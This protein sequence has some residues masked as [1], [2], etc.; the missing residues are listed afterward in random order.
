MDIPFILVQSAEQP[1]RVLWKSPSERS[2]A[3]PQHPGRAETRSKGR[4]KL[5][6]QIGLRTFGVRRQR[7]RDTTRG[8]YWNVLGNNIACLVV[9]AGT[10]WQSPDRDSNPDPSTSHY[11][12]LSTHIPISVPVRY[13]PRATWV[14][15]RWAVVLDLLDCL[16][17]RGAHSGIRDTNSAPS[18]FWVLGFSVSATPTLIQQYP[19]WS[20]KAWTMA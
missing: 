13:L 14:Q 17:T 12:S 4:P 5:S 2:K 15:D 1:H 10:N 8:L 19:S 20:S 3:T 7:R 16:F 6:K 18:V 11:Q 9:S